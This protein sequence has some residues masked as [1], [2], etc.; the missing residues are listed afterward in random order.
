[1]KEHCVCHKPSNPDK[2]LIQCDNKSCLQWLHEQCLID[3]AIDRLCKHEGIKRDSKKSKGGRD[4]VPFKVKMESQIDP[5]TSNKVLVYICEGPRDGTETT[6]T[7]NV[8]CLFCKSPLSL[9]ETEETNGEKAED[10]M[11]AEN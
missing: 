1:M 9:D 3:A 2:R 11:D 5:I 4:V 10:K 8:L 6:L 7:E